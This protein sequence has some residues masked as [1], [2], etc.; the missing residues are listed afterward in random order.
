MSKRPPEVGCTLGTRLEPGTYSAYCAR[1][2]VYRDSVYKRWT[3]LLK[4]DLIDADSNVVATGIPMWLNLGSREKPHAGRRTRYFQE[5]FKA[6]G[7]PPKRADRL[8]PSVF[9]KR[10][11]KVEVGDV[12]TE[13]PYSVVRKILT[14][15]TGVMAHQLIN[16]STI[17]EGIGQRASVERVTEKQ[18]HSRERAENEKRA[19]C[20][21]DALVKVSALAGVES[22]QLN[23]T[24]G[25]ETDNSLPQRHYNAILPKANI[26]D[27][28]AL[29]QAQ[30]VAIERVKRAT[31]ETGTKT[32]A[33][34]MQVQGIT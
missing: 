16:Q 34:A 19:T 6:N 7:A 17:K 25:R 3:C 8:P 30:I 20:E 11:A 23:P 10:I 28:R 14:W 18:C 31:Y 24:Q 29:L 22:K 13:V 26:R 15:E 4:Y 2:D 32:D 27:R 1:A 9:V 5:W 12:K 21:N 33:N